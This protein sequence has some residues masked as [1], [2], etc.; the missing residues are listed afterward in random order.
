MSEEKGEFPG[1]TFSST[2]GKFS[3]DSAEWNSTTIGNKDD[4]VIGFYTSVAGPFTNKLYGGEY[5]QYYPGYKVDIGGVKK[6]FEASWLGF[7]L[8]R[9]KCSTNNTDAISNNVSVHSNSISART[10]SIDVASVQTESID[11]SLAARGMSLENSQL[12]VDNTKI[13]Q[14]SNSV[15]IHD[16]EIRKLVLGSNLESNQAS[17]EN[18]GI[19]VIERRLT[20]F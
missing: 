13:K 16:A 17:V 18:G 8:D 9:F 20:V 10:D 15:N 11:L 12:A 1:I 5:V 2:D 14:R 19:K 3:F 4:W 6:K 7:S